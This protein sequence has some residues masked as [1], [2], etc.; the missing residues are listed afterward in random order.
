MKGMKMPGDNNFQKFQEEDIGKNKY[1]RLKGRSSTTS[2]TDSKTIHKIL[3]SK[4][5]TKNIILKMNEMKNDYPEKYYKRYLKSDL[6]NLIQNIIV[7][8]IH[9]IIILLY[10]STIQACPNNISLNECIEKIDIYYYYRIMLECFVCGITISLIIILVLLK[11]IYLF[12]IFIVIGE[13]VIFICVG[14]KNDIYKNGLFS[15]KVLLEFM[16]ICF[17][18][19]LFFSLFLINL[20]KKHVFY[21]TFFFFAFP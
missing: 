3:S 18:F 11:L 8:V 6:F 20:K 2:S 14:H 9:L 17:A 13:F 15:F 21:S 7:L 16:F 19:F 12:H 5:T 4:S 10:L 1:N